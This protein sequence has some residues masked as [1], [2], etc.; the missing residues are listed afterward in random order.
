MKRDL[1][2][3]LWEGHTNF[4]LAFADKSPV[5][6]SVHLYSLGIQS[7]S[8]QNLI[9]QPVLTAGGWPLAEA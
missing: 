2:N 5:G 8:L 6:E 3:L 4:C 1:D 7:A 9:V